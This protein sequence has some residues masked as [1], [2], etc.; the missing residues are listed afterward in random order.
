MGD[1]DGLPV[2]LPL[3]DL[4][5]G[6]DVV[7]EGV[8]GIVGGGIC[9]GVGTTNPL[10]LGGGPRRVGDNVGGVGCETLGKLVEDCF[11][12]SLDGFCFVGLSDGRSVE[13]SF[14]GFFDGAPVGL[15]DGTSVGFGSLFFGALVGSPVTMDGAL[16]G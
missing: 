12:S 14:D 5:V 13:S 16:V 1:K 7:I 3:N 4:L 2:E 15:G 11:E 8:V 10:E 6:T 9:P